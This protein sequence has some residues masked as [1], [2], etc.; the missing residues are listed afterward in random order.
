[1]T[2]LLQAV[3]TTLVRERSVVVRAGDSDLARARR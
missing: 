3:E 2:L 1:V